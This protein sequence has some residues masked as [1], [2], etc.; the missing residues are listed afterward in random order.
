MKKIKNYPIIKEDHRQFIDEYFINGFS[1]IEAARKLW[2]ESPPATQRTKGSLILKSSLNKDYIRLKQVETQEQ[3][4]I[5]PS[6]IARELKTLAFADLTV[7]LGKTEDQIKQLPPEQRRALSKVT[8]KDKV[9]TLKDGTHF[10]ET[11]RI[12]QLKD[13][14]GA[15]RDLA[16]HNIKLSFTV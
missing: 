10:E 8:I 9:T 1:Q 5:T 11:T 14:L 3:A 4:K 6:E 2:P 12:Y 13:T 16:K 7:F 15:M